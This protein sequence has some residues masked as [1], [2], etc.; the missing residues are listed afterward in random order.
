MLHEQSGYLYTLSIEEFDACAAARQEHLQAL[1]LL[2]QGVDGLRRL[3]L[4]GEEHP[5]A[6]Q[7]AHRSPSAPLMEVENSRCERRRGDSNGRRT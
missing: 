1:L 4:I 3:P 6:A 2:G 5:A 7:R